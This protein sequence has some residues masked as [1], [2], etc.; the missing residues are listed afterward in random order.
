MEWLVT[1]RRSAPPRTIAPAIRI[2]LDN[3]SVA[4]NAGKIPNGS[5]QAT[6]IKFRELAKLWL[7]KDGKTLTVQWIPGY[8][9]IK[10]NEIADSEARGYAS[11]AV[12]PR[13]CI[14]QS[15]SNAKR[16]IRKSKDVAW[17]LE[18]ENQRQTG[19]PLLY[20]ELIVPGNTKLAQGATQGGLGVRDAYVG[21][22]L[23][24]TSGSR[25]SK[26]RAIYTTKPCSEG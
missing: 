10:G 6:F 22:P 17:Q 4:K 16:Q 14:T 20:L 26:L 21:F 11:K 2:R 1:S 19:A 15:L 24:H 18:W 5:S 7:A 13:S 8:E 3:L 25:V 9:G 12:D 23:L